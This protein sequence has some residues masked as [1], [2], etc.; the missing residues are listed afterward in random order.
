MFYW[1]IFSNILNLPINWLYSFFLQKFI[2]LTEMLTSEKS[3]VR[4]QRTGMRCCQD[5]MLG[6]GKHRD[7]A[8]G[9]SA[10]QQ[11]D[12]GPILLIDCPNHGIC[13][14]L[15]ASA[16]MG[17]RLM[18]AYSQNGV[19]KKHS[20]LRPF[21]QITIIRNIASAVIMKFLINVDQ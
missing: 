8:L 13:K 7:L 9:R 5:K 2:R 4:R 17:I 3:A 20:L 11:I 19:Q 12:D 18:G 15:P 14:L 1:K 6:I 10:P 21:L 16:L